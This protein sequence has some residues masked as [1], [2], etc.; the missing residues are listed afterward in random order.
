MFL[1]IK[2]RLSN[3]FDPS[4]FPVPRAWA[5]TQDGKYS[6]CRWPE[7]SS[8]HQEHLEEKC[9]STNWGENELKSH[10]NR[11]GCVWFFLAIHQPVQLHG[12]RL[13]KY[14]S[15][16]NRYNQ[17]IVI[18]L[19]EWRGKSLRILERTPLSLSCEY[20]RHAQNRLTP[21]T[22]WISENLYGIVQDSPSHT[23]RIQRWQL[24]GSWMSSWSSSTMSGGCSPSWKMIPASMIS[25]PCRLESD[26]ERWEGSTI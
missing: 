20:I 1:E 5:K 26:L 15:V 16:N 4:P 25:E 6:T 17:I 24:F 9:S 13:C 12:K 18:I 2:L 10:W 22:A 8:P 19:T 21:R 11:L 3:Y 7:L 23:Q 14:P